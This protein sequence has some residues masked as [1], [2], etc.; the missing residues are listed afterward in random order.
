MRPLLRRISVVGKFC[1]LAPLTVGLVAALA[2]VSCGDGGGNGTGPNPDDAIGSVVV[3]PAQATVTVGA[4]VQLDATVLNGRGET[5]HL[6]PQWISSSP[7]IASVDD[8]GLVTGLAA[9]TAMVSASAGGKSGSASVTVLDPIPP[10][11]GRRA[12]TRS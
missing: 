6:E 10:K 2:T 9:G 3:S 11:A 1:S 5:L 7:S 4:T 8:N 12:E